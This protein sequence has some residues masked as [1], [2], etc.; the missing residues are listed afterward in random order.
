MLEE[1]HLT[2]DLL[3]VQG[4]DGGAADED[5]HASSLDG[6]HALPLIAFLEDGGPA[7]VDTRLQSVPEQAEFSGL[8]AHG[9]GPMGRAIRH[10][11][12]LDPKRIIDRDFD[13]TDRGRQARP[14]ISCLLTPVAA[15]SQ[16]AA[17]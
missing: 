4:V 17:A 13:R 1:R 14:P 2:E 8:P 9:R 3:F 7:G 12:P 6:E 11:R 15:S 10:S 16:G 5:R